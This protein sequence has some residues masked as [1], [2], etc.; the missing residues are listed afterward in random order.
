M[1]TAKSSTP[2]D[3]DYWYLDNAG[4]GVTVYVIDSGINHGP[5]TGVEFLDPSNAN[6]NRVRDTIQYTD[7]NTPNDQSAKGHG[8]GV[9]SIVGGQKYG[10]F[11]RSLWRQQDYCLPESCMMDVRPC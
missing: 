4:K 9:A 5:A 2:R 7:D 11:T 3:T 10:M 8:T 6:V 1:S